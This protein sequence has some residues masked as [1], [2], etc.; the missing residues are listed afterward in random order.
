MDYFAVIVIVSAV[1]L[2][3]VIQQ[4]GII[5]ACPRTFFIIRERENSLT[6]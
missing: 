5:P 6:K 2:V 3:L 1:A 4:E